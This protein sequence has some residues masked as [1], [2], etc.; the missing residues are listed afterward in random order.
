VGSGSEGK[1]GPRFAATPS[2]GTSVPHVGSTFGERWEVG[3]R[4][5][6]GGMASVHAGNDL[7]LGRPVAI[8]ILH[9]HIA[10][11]ADA[12][13]RLAREARAI[14]Q[15]EHEN[16]IQVY[17][18]SIDD[19]D[20]TYLVT[21]LVDGCSL[22][23]FLDRHTEPPPPEVATMIVA[24]VVRALKAAHSVGV[25]HRD[26]KPD[27]I[28]I[29]KIEGRPKLSDFGV[30]K[31]AAESKMTLTGNLVGSP[32][33][34]S[35]EQAD[36]EAIDHRSDLYSTGILFYR[37]VTGTLPFR[38]QTPIDTIRKVSSGEFTDP[39]ELQPNC[40]SAVAAIIR[41]A[42]TKEIDARYQS[43]DEMLRDLA[44]VL[45]D[46][47]L[48][49][50]WDE[51]PKFFAN[52]ETYFAEIRPRLAK[53]LEA[54]GRALLAAGEEGRAV[55]CFNRAIALGDGSQNTVDLVRQLS[56]R[57]NAGRIR[58]LAL[59]SALAVGGIAAITGVLLVT[60]LLSSRPPP[61]NALA[62]TPANIERI[63]AFADEPPPPREPPAIV[64]APAVEPPPAETPKR[65]ERKRRTKTPR[66]VGAAKVDPK[67]DEAP[68]VKPEPKVE[69]EA[70]EEPKLYGTLHVG[71]QKW[72]DVYVDGQKIGRAPDRT[73]YPLPPG[74][75][76]LRAEQPGSNCLPFERTFTISAGETT[77]IRLKVVCP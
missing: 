9:H 7:R 21:E 65:E 11:S 64:P 52:P 46:A 20:R 28:L 22:R 55:D 72:V 38:G 30:A 45:Q 19:P 49:A 4:I 56:R 23:Q 51:L 69:A 63:E 71:A 74:E 61:P 77:R 1:S 48:S 58:K 31:V 41:R 35:P 68:E 70:K 12:R 66:A 44:V 2:S 10:E 59:A 42:L 39:M 15:L 5:G 40:P 32:S 57:R 75:H 50:T 54:R 37:L 3:A 6:M 14:A 76:R 53:E 25:V 34:M 8:K 47:G 13:E 26:V 43:A 36:G 73:Q 24:E 17:D 29:G 33:Y 18:Y 62:E 60:D 27:N 67:L 16:V